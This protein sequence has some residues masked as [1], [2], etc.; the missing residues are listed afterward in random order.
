MSISTKN[1]DK[2]IKALKESLK[3]SEQQ[4]ARAKNLLKNGGDDLTQNMKSIYESQIKRG[5]GLQKN[6]KG[7]IK[8]AEATQKFAKAIN[9]KEKSVNKQSQATSKKEKAL[10]KRSKNLDKVAKDLQAASKLTKESAKTSPVEGASATEVGADTRLGAIM[11]G[12]ITLMKSLGGAIIEGL[13]SIVSELFG[14]KNTADKHYSGDLDALNLMSDARI[15]TS[16][17]ANDT[18]YVLDKMDNFLGA[19]TSLDL[20]NPKNL[21]TLDALDLASNFKM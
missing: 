18:E 1:L 6:L 16:V 15:T 10:E 20:F 2:S 19:D 3:K 17:L 7:M 9:K 8:T 14:S 21:E 5:Q 13:S 4:V 11:E 12:G